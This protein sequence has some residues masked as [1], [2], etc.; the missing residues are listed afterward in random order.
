MQTKFNAGG[1]S[2][3]ALLGTLM[4][5]GCVQP[6]PTQG[7]PSSRLADAALDAGYP[8]MALSVAD[9]ILARDPNNVPALVARGDALFNSGRIDEAAD[10][11]RK[12]LTVQPGDAGAN[13]GLGRIVVRHDP[14]AADRMFR[15]ALASRPDNPVLLANL[16]VALDLQQ[17]HVEAQTAYRHSLQVAPNVAATKA[18]L[19]LSL[20]LTGDRT[21]AQQLLAPLAADP[22]A[23]DVVRANLAVA[24][25]HAIAPAPATPPAPTPVAPAAALPMPAVS[26]AAAPSAAAPI[27]PAPTA[28]AS[29]P[30]VETPAPP[31]DEIT[32]S[33]VQLTAADTKAAATADWERESGRN[34]TLLANRSP[35][36]T[37]TEVNGRSF[38]R[39]RVP[40]ASSLEGRQLCAQLETKGT[41]CWTASPRL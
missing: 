29:A 15:T 23:A 37:E 6:G 33:F 21:G 32:G 4:V 25:M 13:G 11:Y 34:A 39:L 12:A 2:V 27:A 38:W 31:S 14:N 19:G 16:G 3:V 22:S 41:Y 28:V 36:I 20:A 40:V 7:M 1:W 35:H 30:V 18:N 9:H 10:A 24:Q 5:A 17:R 8:Q 26:V